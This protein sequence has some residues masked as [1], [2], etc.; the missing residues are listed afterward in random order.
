M[1][2]GITAYIHC[3]SRLFRTIV[4]ERFLTVV[5]EKESS[6]GLQFYCNCLSMSH[7]IDQQSILFYKRILRSSSVILC[8]LLRF[9]QSDICA[10]LAK[11][12]IP[13]LSL[14]V[15]VYLKKQKITSAR[16]EELYLEPLCQ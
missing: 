12:R 10:L 7:I 4:L 14:I 9:K 3:S 16:T 6:A 15:F 1:E 8:T 5:G 2:Y 11:Y 13:S